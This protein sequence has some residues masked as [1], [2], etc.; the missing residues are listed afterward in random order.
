LEAEVE[1]LEIELQNA[2]L[3]GFRGLPEMDAADYLNSNKA[4]T[5]RDED[6][7]NSDGNG[8]GLTDYRAEDSLQVDTQTGRTVFL[9]P[10]SIPPRPDP[11][12]PENGTLASGY[13]GCGL[14]E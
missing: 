10:T 9:G 7:D 6:S 8:Q 4:V 11:G 2:R 14:P 5:H 13:L 12:P 3:S 1:R